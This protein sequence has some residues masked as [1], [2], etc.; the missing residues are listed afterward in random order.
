MATEKT[1]S[2]RR[3]PCRTPVYTMKNGENLSLYSPFSFLLSFWKENY[4]DTVQRTFA[5]FLS[6]SEPLLYGWN[7][8]NI[9]HQTINHGCREFIVIQEFAWK[10]CRASNSVHTWSDAS[11]ICFLIYKAFGSTILS[12]TTLARIWVDIDFKSTYS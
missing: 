12:K 3:Q 11:K 2:Q 6:K 10:W 5:G 8:V 4:C 7:V 9:K 1:M